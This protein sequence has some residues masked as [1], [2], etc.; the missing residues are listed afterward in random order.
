MKGREKEKKKKR[1][2]RR[3]RGANLG[4]KLGKNFKVSFQ[5]SSQDEFNDQESEAFELGGVE[6]SKPVVVRA[7]EEETPSSSCMVGFEDRA[8]VVSKSDRSEG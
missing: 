7:G 8:I 5:I 6:R 4:I 1:K 2:R 3:R